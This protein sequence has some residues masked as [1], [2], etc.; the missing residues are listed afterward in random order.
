M[1]LDD[2]SEDRIGLGSNLRLNRE[3]IPDF[4]LWTSETNS[5]VQVI[6]DFYKNRINC[7]SKIEAGLPSLL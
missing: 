3:N 5:I 7:E 2:N 1:N 4:S 6:K